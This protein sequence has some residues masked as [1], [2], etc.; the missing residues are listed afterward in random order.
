ML[1]PPPPPK[2]LEQNIKVDGNM[3]FKPSCYAGGSY[4]DIYFIIPD[5]PITGIIGQFLPFHVGRNLAGV[6]NGYIYIYI[7]SYDT[8]AMSESYSKDRA[9]VRICHSVNDVEE[10]SHPANPGSD[11][12]YSFTA[13]ISEIPK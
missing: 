1:Y 11:K 8:Y 6:Y 3:F 13:I 4:V 5:S 7:I 9:V 12:D 10:N 2:Y